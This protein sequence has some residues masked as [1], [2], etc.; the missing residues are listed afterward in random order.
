MRGKQNQIYVLLRW[1]LSR[2]LELPATGPGGEQGT[3][4][5]SIKQGVP[6]T[7]SPGEWLSESSAK[8][9]WQEQI[10]QRLQYQAWRWRTNLGTKRRPK[11]WPSSASLELPGFSLQ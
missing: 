5:R 6:G 11:S 4:S 2:V 9:A 8:W 7:V 3:I 1:V 10:K